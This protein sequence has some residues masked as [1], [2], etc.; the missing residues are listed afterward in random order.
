MTDYEIDRQEN[1]S[2]VG[3]LAA[4]A[5]C[6]ALAVGLFLYADGYFNPASSA[7][8]ADMPAVFIEAK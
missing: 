6:V 1:N 7:V 2:R 4:G 8:D 5:L 3:W